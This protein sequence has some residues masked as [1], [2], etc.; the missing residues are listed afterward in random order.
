MNVPEMAA[1]ARDHWKKTDPE[2]YLKLKQV[3]DLEKGS[4]AAAKLTL[5]EMKSLMLIKIPGQEAWQESRH[6][7]IFRTKDQL[8]ED[9]PDYIQE[10]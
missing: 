1:L 2:L 5:A 9:F 3:G 8:R 10:D 6:L 7:F 4:E